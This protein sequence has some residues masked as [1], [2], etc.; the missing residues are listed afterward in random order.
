MKKKNAIEKTSF[1]SKLYKNKTMLFMLSPAMIYVII[2]SYIPMFGIVLAFKNYNYQ[3][4]IFG[5]PWVAFDN[6]K[7]LLISNKLWTLSRNT[8][9]YNIAFLGLGLIFEVGFAIILSEITN[10]IFKRVSQGIMFLPYFISWVVVSSIMITLF[11]YEHGVL[12]NILNMFGMESF[13]LYGATKQWP[14][15]MVFLRM[16]KL[17]GYGSVVYLAAITG[18]SQELFEA[19][20]IDGANIWNKIR[21]ITIPSIKPTMSIMLLLGLGNVFRGDF[22]MFYQIVKNNQLLLR[23]SDIIDTFVYRSLMSS[24]NLGMS[25]AAGMYQSVMCLIV[26]STVNY[27]IKRIQPD[28]A[29]F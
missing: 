4:G 11:G 7:F 8:I 3:A 17:T 25:A 12:N 23:S 16:W 29:L 1:L 10:G 22:G 21:H 15:V 2:F 14:F 5:S 18:I 19:A 9:L 13:N 6:F 28:Y 27:I 26:I 20:E 24:P